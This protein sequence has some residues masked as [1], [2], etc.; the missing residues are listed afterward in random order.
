MG[1]YKLLGVARR[2]PL[3]ATYLDVK[4]LND[5]AQSWRQRLRHL[6][7]EHREIRTGFAQSRSIS[8][9]YGYS[10]ELTLSA[11][12]IRQAWRMYR[13][14]QRDA[15]VMRAVYMKQVSLNREKNGRRRSA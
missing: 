1:I 4:Y 7:A 11:R 15:A 8:E 2:E 5:T 6:V 10:Q 9:R 12:H 3:T 13:D 14:I